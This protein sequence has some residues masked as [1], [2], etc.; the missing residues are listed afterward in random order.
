MQCELLAKQLFLY[1]VFSLYFWNHTVLVPYFPYLVFG[2]VCLCSQNTVSVPSHF[3]GA[4]SSWADRSAAVPGPAAVG[5]L[6]PRT[7]ACSNGSALSQWESWRGENL[8][9]LWWDCSSPPPA[10]MQL[11]LKTSALR[12][13]GLAIEWAHHTMGRPGLCTCFH[14]SSQ[15][16]SDARCQIAFISHIYPFLS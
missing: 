11:H 6:L 8:L 1:K 2:V 4:A 14:T 7:R 5:S 12:V 9:S 15:Q 13:K 16:A 10:V 3:S